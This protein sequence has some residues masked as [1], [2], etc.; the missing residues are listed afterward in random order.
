MEGGDEAEEVLEKGE[1]E[2]SGEKISDDDE[3]E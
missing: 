1:V 2:D 3:V